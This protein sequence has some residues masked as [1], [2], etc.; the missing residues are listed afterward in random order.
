M[1]LAR[2]DI[3]DELRSQQKKRIVFFV[4]A[5]VIFFAIGVFAYE[6]Y[7]SH[8][9]FR[10]RKEITIAQGLGSRAIG[11]LLKQEGVVSSKWFF[12]IYVSLRGEASGLKPG[13]YE[14]LDTETIPEI[15]RDLIAGA[16]RER[17]ITIP[18]G[19][20]SRDIARFFAEQNI[21]LENAAIQF[22]MHPSE[23]FVQRFAFLSERLREAGLE[24]YLFPDTYRIFQD[25]TLESVV[26]KMLNNFDRKMTPDLRTEITSQK[27][28]MHDV[29]TM[30]S[31]IEKEVA[32][33]EDRAIVAGILWKRLD[34]GIPL[35]VDATVAYAKDKSKKTKVKSGAEISLEDK[36]IN[37]PYNTYKYRGLP[38]GPIA[39]PGLS[40]IHAAIYPKSSP[41]LYYLSTPDG[42]TIFSKTLDEH[43]AA[44]AKYLR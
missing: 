32:T 10:G 9:S 8:A 6:V 3:G 30:A 41:Y 12:V 18:E 2:Q 14:F 28:T 17:A 25:A 35:Q 44:K 5:A 7:F 1:I 22:F 34:A 37:S 36:K 43:N 16:V 11:T 24:G 33:D 21:A 39:N 15:S 23:D 26:I 20:S 13:R 40:A 31:L 42:R 19:W 27:K 38:P 4:A 29:T